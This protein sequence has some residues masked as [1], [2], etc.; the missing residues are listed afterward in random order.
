MATRIVRKEVSGKE[1][2]FPL[3]GLK[4]GV[5]ISL[6]I[7]RV[8]APAYGQL[9]EGFSKI[10]EQG[11]SGM[12]SVPVKDIIINCIDAMEEMDVNEILSKF[13]KDML[14]DDRPVTLDQAFAGNYG[15]LLECVILAIKENFSSFFEASIFKDLFSDTETE[16]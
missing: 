3:L 6:K 1:V 8:A 9:L 2:C 12:E 16:K 11:A 10:R 15:F 13:F 7:A 14:I 4:D 5:T